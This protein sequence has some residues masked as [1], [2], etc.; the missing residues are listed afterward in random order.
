MAP[1]PDVR[2]EMNLPSQVAL[3]LAT[4]FKAD[5]GID[6]LSFELAYLS[7]EF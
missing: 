4:W 3:L 5:M 1:R 7:Q 2:K 6:F